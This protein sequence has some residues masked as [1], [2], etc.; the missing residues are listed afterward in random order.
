[1]KNNFLNYIH[2]FRGFAII[3]IVGVHCRTSID[4]PKDSIIHDLLF[5]GLDF[6]TILFVFI[7]GFLFQYVHAEKLNYTRYLSKKLQYVVIPYILVSIPAILD[8]LLIET[9]AHW[10]TDY[11][12]GLNTFWQ[13]IYMLCTGKHSGPFYFIPMICLI[14]ILAPL[15]YRIQK[16]RFFNFL[17]AGVVLLGMFSYNYGYYAT[18]WE[19]LVYF[20]PVY[21]FGIWAGKNH[22]WLSELS[23]NILLLLVGIY[24]IIFYLEMINV[25]DVYRLKSFKEPEYFTPIFNWGKFKVMLL[26]II[27]L[28]IFYR[29][30]QYDFSLLTTLGNYSFGVYFIHIYFI[31]AISYLLNH[32]HLSITQNLLIFVCY[33]AFVMGASMTCVF[34]IKKIFPK[35]SRLLVGS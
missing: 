30:K 10:M 25:I 33:L 31:N 17:M 8:K 22:S 28:N 21:I 18:L 9:N 19:S 26:A 1:M 14:F 4:W 13:I 7:S 16:W 20:V 12:K 15:F 6:A 5:Y 3:L 29:L 32:F 27:F 35:R 34:V 2:N 23:T 11:Y 24:I